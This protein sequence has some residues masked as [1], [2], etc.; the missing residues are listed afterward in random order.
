MQFNL[1]ED[2][3]KKQFENKLNKMLEL[4]DAAPL[5]GRMK[6]WIVNHYV[7]SKL[8]WSFT[9]QNYSDTV[10][11]KCQAH[12]HRRYRKWFGLAK[13]VEGSLLYRTHEHFGLK[14]KG[15]PR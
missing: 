10:A 6:A 13:S 4:V 3:I 2:L 8:A 5:D 12:I 1:K 14:L 11:K 7:Y 9:V 15:L